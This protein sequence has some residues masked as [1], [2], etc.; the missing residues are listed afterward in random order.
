MP[1]SDI[2][3]VFTNGFRTGA[4][5]LDEDDFIAGMNLMALCSLDTEVKILC[6]CLMDNHVHFILKG[7]GKCCRDFIRRYRRRY[8]VLHKCKYPGMAF[9]DMQVGIKAIDTE[10]YLQIALAYVLRNP[11]AAGYPYLPSSYRWSSAGL[12]MKE[13][14]YMLEGLQYLAASEYR[15]HELRALLKTHQSIPG[16]W[17]IVGG[18]LIW[19]GS[20]VDYAFVNKVFGHPRRYM[21]YMSSTQEASVADIVGVTEDV[22]MPEHELRRKALD[23][24]VEMFGT[25]SLSD[26]KVADRLV[27]ARCLKRKYGASYKQIARLVHLDSQYLKGI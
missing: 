3:H 20:Y 12:Y 17:I 5:F 1:L 15:V 22:F 16:D 13:P 4:M 19:P 26:L 21:Y 10:E 7:D 27:L 11:V 8:S 9:E 25:E 23:M 18:R 2:Y 6:F 14:R 24:T